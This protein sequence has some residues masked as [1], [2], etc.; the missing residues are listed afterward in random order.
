ME[1]SLLVL[2]DD[3]LRQLD[4]SASDWKT[5]DKVRSVSKQTRRDGDTEL[6]HYSF[7]GLEVF[8]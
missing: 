3:F 7:F 2:L 6:L 1:V 5:T 4:L 8:Q